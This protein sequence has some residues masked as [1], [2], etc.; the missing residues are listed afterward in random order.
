MK[1]M[2][3][4]LLALF[5][6]LLTLTLLGIALLAGMRYLHAWL[7]VLLLSQLLDAFFVWKHRWKGLTASVLIGC[8]ARLLAGVLGTQMRAAEEALISLQRC[9]GRETGFCVIMETGEKMKKILIVED[10]ASLQEELK[11]LLDNNGYEGRILHSFSNVAQ[12]ILTMDVDLVLL[13]ILIPTVN[14]Q[15]VLKAVRAK[16]DVPI[17][18]VTSKNSEVD[19]VLSMSYGADDY[20]T[21]P[22][23]QTLLLLHIEAVFKRINKQNA[24]DVYCGV[25]VNVLRSTLEKDGQELLLSKNEMAIFHYLLQHKGCIVS[26]DELMDYLWDTNKFIDDNTLTVNIT[27]L[28]KKLEEIGLV[29]V[30]ETRRGQGYLLV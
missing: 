14:G 21:K 3:C 6:L 13:D 29:D 11:I 22:Y 30:I 7:P 5:P 24:M 17:I 1:R 25:A 16:S 23:N 8:L 10:D 15:Q 26:R 28:R 4:L 27:R 18:M 20:I 12:A 19:E 9:K 2:L